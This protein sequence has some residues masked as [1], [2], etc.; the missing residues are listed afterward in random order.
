[1][2]T[3][4]FKIKSPSENSLMNPAAHFLS[5]CQEAESCIAVSLSETVS[6]TRCVLYPDTTVCGLSS[7]PSSSSPTSSCR[8][9]LREPASQ[10]YLRTGKLRSQ[11]EKRTASGWNVSQV[12]VSAERLPSTTSV[13][14]PGRGN[15]QGFTV[16]TAVGSDRKKVVQFLGVPYARPP[17]GSLRFEAAQPPDWTGTWEAT[18]PRYV[19]HMLD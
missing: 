19:F 7:A 10:V 8:L 1:M 6:A 2:V 15:L 14:I 11:S 9:V 5:A 4:S 18:K 12:C 17:V 13:S 3:T 16:E